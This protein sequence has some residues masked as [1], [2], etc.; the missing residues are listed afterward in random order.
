MHACVC[1]RV[2]GREAVFEHLGQGL[3]EKGVVRS[4]R[5][6]LPVVLSFLSAEPTTPTQA[7]VLWVIPSHFRKG[8][9]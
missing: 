3:D 8:C 9:M 4:L 7:A 6:P 2:G 5:V 1:A